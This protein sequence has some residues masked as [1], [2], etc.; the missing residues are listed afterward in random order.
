MQNINNLKAAV[1]ACLLI[2]VTAVSFGMPKVKY[3][4]PE[5]ISKL[6]IPLYLNNWR[7]QDISGKLSLGDERYNFISEVF[8]R[9]YTNKYGESLLFLI[10]DAGNFHDPKVCFGSAGYKNKDLTDTEFKVNNHIVRAST[11]FFEKK[12]GNYLV[13]Y[14]ICVDKKRIDWT[15]QK[16]IQ[17][18]YSLFNKEK[19]GLMVRLDIP[20]YADKTDNAVKLAREFIDEIAVYIP[21]NQAEY[22]FGE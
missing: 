17:L 8:A 6:K 5:I 4:S 12:D 22:I 15:R 10:L 7:G 21:S 18:F 2:L 14:W 16:I 19:I 3:K 1:I 13:I 9:A 11:V 20:I